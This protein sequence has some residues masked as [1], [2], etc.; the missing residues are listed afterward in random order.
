MDI[1]QR[2]RWIRRTDGPERIDLLLDE[3]SVNGGTA[4][5]DPDD[6]IR[7]GGGQTVHGWVWAGH[8]EELRFIAADAA[9]EQQG[10]RD[11]IAERAVDSVVAVADQ[12]SPSAGVLDIHF[13]HFVAMDSRAPAEGAR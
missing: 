9:G 7:H 6:R 2:A 10:S 5:A 11:V 12:L 8:R 1:Q 4:A 3:G 13:A